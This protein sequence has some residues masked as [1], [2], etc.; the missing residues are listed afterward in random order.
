MLQQ[1]QHSQAQAQVPAPGGMSQFLPS[2]L[3]APGAVAGAGAALVGP[4]ANVYEPLTDD[5][6]SL[7]TFAAAAASVASGD[8]ASPS[9]L[10]SST[11]SLQP[12]SKKPRSKNVFRQCT[13]P[14]CT[15]GARGKSGLCQKHGGGKR[16]SVPN[17]P[18]GAQGSSS[19]CLFHGGG[20][21]CTVPGCST[22]ARGTSG[23]CAKH[24]GYKRARGG[25]DEPESGP[26]PA[27]QPRMEFQARAI[28]GQDG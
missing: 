23:L 1:Q 9:D 20:Y 26:V 8:H 12:V 6:A 19:Y 13:T 7:S 4:T 3:Y 14:G 24:G 18:K 2:H 21:R 27:K 22:G 15:K 28:A 10:A 5:Y 16:C 11:Q 17:C 25:S